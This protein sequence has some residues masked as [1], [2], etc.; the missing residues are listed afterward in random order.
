MDKVNEEVEKL[1]TSSLSIADRSSRQKISTDIDNLSSTINYF[2]PTDMYRILH[3][4]R[5]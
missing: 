5:A 3:L 4:T 1:D 2:D